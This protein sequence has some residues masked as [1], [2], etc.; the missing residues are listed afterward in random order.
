[1]RTL[2]QFIDGYQQLVEFVG[3]SIPVPSS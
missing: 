3:Q 2:R 1:V